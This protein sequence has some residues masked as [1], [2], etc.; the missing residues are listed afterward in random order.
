[1]CGFKK[2]SFAE[3][4]VPHEAVEDSDLHRVLSSALL[5]VWDVQW[6]ELISGLRLV[7]GVEGGGVGLTCFSFFFPDYTENAVVLTSG[8]SVLLASNTRYCVWPAAIRMPCERLEI[9]YSVP[10]CWGSDCGRT[11][12]ACWGHFWSFKQSC[13]WLKQC[14][15]AVLL[16]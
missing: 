1:M 16:R 2:L 5:G 9:E 15:F 11:Q 12:A 8:L 7:P 14:P 6:S 3:V 10:Q 4:S 13:L